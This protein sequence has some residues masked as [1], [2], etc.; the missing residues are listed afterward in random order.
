MCVLCCKGILMR[1]LFIIIWMCFTLF[2]ACR[3]QKKGN[4]R[5]IPK[6]MEA[7]VKSTK[8]VVHTTHFTPKS[9]LKPKII[10]EVLPLIYPGPGFIPEPYPIDPPGYIPD[11]VITCVGP[12]D[13]LPK[14]IRDSIVQFPATEAIFGDTFEDFYQ[15][16]HQQIMDSE[17]FNYL[18]E[19]GLSGKIFMRLLIDAKGKV[20]EVT[21]LKFTDKQL[22]ILKSRLNLALLDMPNWNPAKDQNGQNVVSE[23]TFPLKI[24][25]E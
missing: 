18:Y 14:T 23:F 11:P 8:K 21:F 3:E 19:L 5:P 20:R 25:F 10:P 1:Q 17:E 6:K 12:P 15:F 9:E 2:S 24:H 22:E 16:L 4:V 13:P 7:K